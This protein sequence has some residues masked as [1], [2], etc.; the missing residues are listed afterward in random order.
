[1]YVCVYIYIYGYVYNVDRIWWW[2]G[3]GPLHQ[4]KYHP[5]NGGPQI[6]LIDPILKQGEMM[7]NGSVVGQNFD[8]KSR[9]DLAPSQDPLQSVNI[10]WHIMDR[11]TYYP[12]ANHGAG[13]FTVIN[14]P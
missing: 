9:I 2:Y 10:F 11:W 14:A 1:M 6:T 13:I 3:S 5:H 7:V 4:M 8:T 12:C